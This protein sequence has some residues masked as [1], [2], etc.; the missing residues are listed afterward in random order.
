[1]SNFLFKN[2][3][4]EYKDFEYN[5][6]II[7]ERCVEVS[8]AEKFIKEIESFVEIGCVTPHYYNHNNKVYDLTDN[9][10]KAINKD[11]D[12]IDLNG[13]NILSISTIEHF[14]LNDYN[15]P[16]EI[17]KA[18]NFLKKILSLNTK[19]LITWALGVNIE[20]DEYA[21][22]NVEN[23]KFISKILL[24]NGQYYWKEKDIKDLSDI[25]KTYGTH[26]F[27]N[28]VAIIENFL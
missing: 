18:V 20:L 5:R 14:G 12:L 21:L 22:S 27:A 26:M 24:D 11:A 16:V 23:I 19:H 4:F 13:K 8:L 6:T 2:I 9:H 7:N 25:D 1:M 17:G 28:T 3:S 15:N 10:P